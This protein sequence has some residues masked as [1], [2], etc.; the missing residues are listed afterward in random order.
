[1]EHGA[2]VPVGKEN[3]LAADAQEVECGRGEVFQHQGADCS[4]HLLL[5]MEAVAKI[6]RE[7]AVP[8]GPIH[9]MVI[10]LQ[11][12]LRGRPGN[13]GSRIRNVPNLDVHHDSE[14]RIKVKSD[15]SSF[16]C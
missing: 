9:N 12:G 3:L 5:V 8:I 16:K 1:M 7:D 11:A 6:A 10:V 15:M 4:R 13:D 2:V 14:T